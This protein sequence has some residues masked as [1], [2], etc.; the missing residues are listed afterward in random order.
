M[1]MFAGDV[2]A[3]EKVAGLGL[4]LKAVKLE[5][6]MEVAET[7][8][9]EMGVESVEVLKELEMIED[10]V[11]ALSLK[12]APAK[13]LR[14]QLEDQDIRAVKP[15]AEEPLHRAI[16][17]YSV[18]SVFAGTRTDVGAGVGA[19]VGA[20]AGAG[21][22]GE[23][24]GAARTS[25]GL[26]FG[27]L[28]QLADLST[29]LSRGFSAAMMPQ[30]SVEAHGAEHGDVG[31]APRTE[32]RSHLEDDGFFGDA[33]VGLSFREAPPSSRRLTTASGSTFR[34]S[35]PSSRV[36][37]PRSSRAALATR[38]YR[39]PKGNASRQALGKHPVA[40][41]DM[42]SVDAA[43][44]DSSKTAGLARLSEGQGEEEDL[45]V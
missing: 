38:T 6:K 4:L 9:D 37:V 30:S 10:F 24:T 15:G 41:D 35:P 20:T 21:S 26:N 34:E 19:G 29:R 45:K 12:V 18:D 39:T 27:G 2:K 32:R 13:L 31:D 8:C 28:E 1:V 25:K 3:G 43:A 14:R 40:S 36:L 23:D 7:W 5:G 33:D 17:R 11:A 16:N 44:D 42:A 22:D